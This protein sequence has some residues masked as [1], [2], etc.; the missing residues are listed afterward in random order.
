MP[1][2][3]DRASAI[4]ADMKATAALQAAFGEQLARLLENRTGSP[5]TVTGFEGA[6]RGLV[7]RKVRVAKKEV[8]FVTPEQVRT[9]ILENWAD[10]IVAD[11]AEGGLAFVDAACHLYLEVEGSL[12]EHTLHFAIT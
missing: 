3:V 12:G 10:A 7:R 1:N 4:L 6:P 5:W 2:L 11:M 8:V 9:R